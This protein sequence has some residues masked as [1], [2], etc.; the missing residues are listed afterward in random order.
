[1]TSLSFAE[2]VRAKEQAQDLDVLVRGGFPSLWSGDIDV[3]A[4]FY[5]AYVAS[6]LERDVR[7][8][9][10]VGDLRDFHRFLRAVA[11]RT[12][13]L[14]NYADLARDVGIAPNSAKAWISVLVASG[15]VT[16]LE[17]YHR[18]LG[19]RLIKS[20]KVYMTDTGLA[21]HLVGIGDRASLLASPLAGALWETFVIG[22]IMRHLRVRR[23]SSPIWYWRTAHGDEVDLL[24]E[25]GARFTAVECKLAET[26]G[27][28]ALRGVHALEEV[29]GKA[30]IERALVVCRTTAPYAARAGRSVRFL[31]VSG[32]PG[33]LG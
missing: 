3:A 9:K 15:Q 7:N 5:T 25:H 11:L 18:S 24:I 1:M 33:A 23:T 19:K 27:P 14:L 20:P 28:D 8:L 32:I 13:Q 4:D 29:H 2:I 30:A 26:P 10:A 31:G 6:Y 17:P 12:G 22:E 21:C 16:L